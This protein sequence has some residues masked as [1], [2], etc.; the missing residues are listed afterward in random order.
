MKLR[1]GNKPVAAARLVVDQVRAAAALRRLAAGFDV[2]VINSVMA[3][4]AAR[5]GLWRTTKVV[6]L[7]HDVITRP[8]FGRIARF[9][10]PAI[11]LAI[12]VSEAAADLPARLGMDSVVVRNGVHFP[13][14]PCQPRPDPPIVGVNAVL[15]PWKG[16]RQFLQAMELVET[17]FEVELLGGRFPKDAEYEAELRSLAAKPALDGR[18]RFLGHQDD[19]LEAMRSWSVAVSASVEPEAGPLAVLEA[20]SIGLPVV[21]TDHGGAPEIAADFG[22]L[23]EPLDAASMACA[24]ERLLRSPDE[25]RVR[26]QQGRDHVAERYTIE[27]SAD[28]FASTLRQVVEEG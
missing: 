4:P 24:V 12:G 28:C 11:D 2:V 14:A 3:L 13:V 21:V 6:W 22:L 10:A 9:S 27:Q 7:V 5:L 17:D 25:Q 26:G 23:A 8:G 18:V 1:G 19:P 15:T 20:M 16:Q